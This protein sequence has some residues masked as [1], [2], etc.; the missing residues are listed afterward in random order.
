MVVDKQQQQ[1]HQ[2]PTDH[3]CTELYTTSS[4]YAT[5]RRCLAW[6]SSNS[7]TGAPPLECWLW[8]QVSLA[9]LCTTFYEPSSN[10][11]H[12]SLPRSTRF[13]YILQSLYQVYSAKEMSVEEEYLIKNV[14]FWGHQTN[15][16]LLSI[17]L[18]T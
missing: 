10:Q 11:Q 7:R 12:N 13:A 1:Q 8:V 18:G 16:F 4:V 9:P 3:R 14:G 5:S 17:L 6:S 15:V 2:R